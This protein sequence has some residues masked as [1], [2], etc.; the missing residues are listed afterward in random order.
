M[1]MLSVRFFAII[2]IIIS[3]T[4]RL[5]ECGHIIGLKDS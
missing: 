5:R 2:I 4:Y 1:E 3:K